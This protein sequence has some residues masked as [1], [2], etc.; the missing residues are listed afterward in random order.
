MTIDWSCRAAQVLTPAELYAALVL[1]ARV[2]VVEQQCVYPDPDG[3]DLAADVWHLFGWRAGELH[4][5]LRLL[6]AVRDEVVIGRVIVAPEGRG[7]G[8]GHRLL[9]EALRACAE[10]WPGRPLFLSAQAHLQAYYGRYGF[11][12]CSA[13]YD[14]D[15]IP[16]IDMRR[17]LA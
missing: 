13:V 4:A 8:L 2:F 16:H 17:S 15:G 12:P 5:Y 14:E 9:E 11:T 6:G 10:R 7:S 1:R 3:L